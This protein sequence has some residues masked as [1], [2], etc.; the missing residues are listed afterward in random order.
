MS[1]CPPVNL[2]LSPRNPSTSELASWLH[3]QNPLTGYRNRRIIFDSYYRL[4][5]LTS[6]LEFA[7]LYPLCPK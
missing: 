4:K 6:C 2:T 1:S 5:G 3:Q 7:Q